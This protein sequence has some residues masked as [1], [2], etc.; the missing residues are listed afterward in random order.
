VNSR[1]DRRDTSRSVNS[2]NNQRLSFIF[3][4]LTSLIRNKLISSKY[5]PSMA[6]KELKKEGTRSALT[7]GGYSYYCQSSYGGKRTYRC[8]SVCAEDGI[9]RIEPSAE[10]RGRFPGATFCKA[11]LVYLANPDGT[12]EFQVHQPHICPAVKGAE[13][14][15]DT[16]PRNEII[17]GPEEEMVV[18]GRRSDA[19]PR[20]YLET[21][22]PS[23][24]SVDDFVL[25]QSVLVLLRAF[26][27]WRF[28]SG[29][30]GGDRFYA[31]QESF[32]PAL[33]A[34][35]EKAMRPYVTWVQSKYPKLTYVRF[36]V[37]KTAAHGLSQFKYHRNRLHSDYDDSVYQ[38][39]FDERPVS[40]MVALDPFELMYLPDY[41]KS[42]S[43]IQT[44]QVQAFNGLCFTN[45]C[46]HSG[47]PNRTD[48][49]VYRLFGYLV[50]RECDFPSNMI[51]LHN[52]VPEGVPRGSP[53]EEHTA[54]MSNT[55]A[56]DA[57]VY[58]SSKRGRILVRADRLAD[59]PV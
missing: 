7:H 37:L 3:V 56:P 44:L 19:D 50:S 45:R 16:V 35:V 8:Q 48:R 5:F 12:Q 23:P 51:W 39:P 53:S 13:P 28:L 49:P 11:K 31:R 18:E 29:G 54:S 41:R 17:H 52:D 2:R 59:Y 25:L 42:N 22:S 40:L 14:E 43:H 58:G 36:G 24:D 57:R 30:G 6:E 33:F 1:N 10:K 21:M 20:P 15:V 27:G 9:W 38:L 55:R 4:S 26:S 46:L 47:G 34:Q 32:S